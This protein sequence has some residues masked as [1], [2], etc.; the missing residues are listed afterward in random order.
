MKRTRKRVF[1]KGPERE[2]G[3]VIFTPMEELDEM[4]RMGYGETPQD[5]IPA[6]WRDVQ[7]PHPWP[8]P[9]VAAS[10][11]RKKKVRSRRGIGGPRL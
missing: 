9:F 3:D 11:W 8:S 5:E 2:A 4:I 1:D 7:G 6:N 10:P